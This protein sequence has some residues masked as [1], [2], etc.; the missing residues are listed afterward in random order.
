MLAIAAA[1]AGTT[2]VGVVTRGNRAGGDAGAGRAAQTQPQERAGTPE[3]RG[4]VLDRA[5]P[6]ALRVPAADIQARL[7]TLSLQSD[8]TVEPPPV[9]QADQPGWYEASPT[10]GEPGPSVIVGHAV[11]QEGKPRPVF[12]DLGK[13]KPGAHVEVARADKVVAVFRVDRVQRYPVTHFPADEV[14]GTVDH[15]ALRLITYTPPS[16]TPGGDAQNV[17]VY[18]SLLKSRAGG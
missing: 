17:V 18:A 3:I 14:Y 9:E 16:G 2:V 5:E 7:L 11:Q 8:G 15:A 12:R 10:P 4:P 6:V 1:V 13:V